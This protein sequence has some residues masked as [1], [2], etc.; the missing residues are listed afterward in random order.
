MS[1]AIGLPAAS[2]QL[3]VYGGVDELRPCLA[4][5]T[6]LWN[7]PLQAAMAEAQPE[8]TDTTGIVVTVPTGQL[9]AGR[10]CERLHDHL[11][12]AL[13][14]TEAVYDFGPVSHLVGYRALGD[15]RL[16]DL[17][18]MIAKHTPLSCQLG[19]RGTHTSPSRSL[20]LVGGSQHGGVD[21]R[22]LPAAVVHGL[23]DFLLPTAKEVNMSV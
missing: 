17:Q 7:V 9:S 19:G 15:D 5:I 1:G 10:L 8:D 2:Y 16:R 14:L 23:N 4:R 18:G 3:L 20:W 11:G 21:I 22:T 13:E 12:L 6:A